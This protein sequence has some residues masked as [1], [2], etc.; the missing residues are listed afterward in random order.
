LLDR[1]IEP[2]ATIYHWDLP[3][4]LED[5]GGWPARD[6]AGRFADYAAIVARAL[7]D[8]VSRWVT[9]NEPW[10]VANHGYGTGRHAPGRKDQAAALATAHH[11]LLG[12][13]LAVKALRA[14][15]PRAAPLGITLNMTVVRALDP[16]TKAA[17]EEQEAAHNWLYLDPVVTGRY[18]TNALPPSKL[19]PP[20]LVRDGDLETISTPIDFLGLNYYSSQSYGWRDPADELRRGETRHDESPPGI[21]EVV[22]DGVKLTATGWP[23]DAE[24]LYDLLVSLHKR[25]PGL[26]IYI[27]ENGMAADDYV[28]P[29]GGVDDDERIAYLRDHL[30]S[31]ARA[32]A[33]G[34]DLRG[35]FC[36][37]LLDNFE[38]AE[39]YSKR[40]GL[41][42]V[43][44]ATQQRI[45]KA[46]AG[47]YSQLARDNA[48]PD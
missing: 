6:T 16:R 8:G 39:G 7:G 24:G 37:S 22:G 26:P 14:E 30:S 47:F 44:Y 18:P 19:P 40:F 31:A 41:V 17:A 12:H 10:V 46:S 29:E 32:I 27:T 2:V 38:W 11:L 34:V 1:D 25:A 48:L 20:E 33:D 5:A 13:G 15:L 35:Y 21:V 23:I 28:D 45:P 43:D 4:P 9:V 3:Q 42:Y 36:W